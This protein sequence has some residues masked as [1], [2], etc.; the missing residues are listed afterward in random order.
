[1]LH[2]GVVVAITGH[3]G[4]LIIKCDLA[5][6]MQSSLAGVRLSQGPP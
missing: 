2:Y 3:R 6:R 4:L 1:M 5:H